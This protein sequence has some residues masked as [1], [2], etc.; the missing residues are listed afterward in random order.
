MP[1]QHASHAFCPFLQWEDFFR[2]MGKT[3]VPLQRLADLGLGAVQ[4]H[5]GQSYAEVLRA[6]P[7]EQG[8]QLEFWR[9][10]PGAVGQP[11]PMSSPSVLAALPAAQCSPRFTPT[12]RQCSRVCHG[13]AAPHAAVQECKQVHRCMQQCNPPAATLPITLH[14]AP[15]P[16]HLAAMYAMARQYGILQHHP[17]AQQVRFRCCIRA[18]APLFGSSGAAVERCRNC[19]VRVTGKGATLKRG[20]REKEERTGVPWLLAARWR[21][22]GS[23]LQ[24]SSARLRRRSA[25]PR[26]PPPGA[27]SV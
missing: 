10:A 14:F 21:S 7:D 6:L 12:C 3:G 2:L 19:L 8:V 5:A 13:S 17:D 18:V 4:Q 16:C 11:L 20:P 25:P 15:A 1:A 24:P 26:F 27:G 22:K 23:T 9:S